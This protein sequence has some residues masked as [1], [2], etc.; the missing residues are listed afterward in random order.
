MSPTGKQSSHH[1][2]G[3]HAMA[4]LHRSDEK[5]LHHKL[6]HYQQ[7]GRLAGQGGQLSDSNARNAPDEAAS[8]VID[9]S[10][11]FLS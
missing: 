2:Q 6:A 3:G 5:S 7:A 9:K 8:E 4:H 1:S 11:Q 10:G